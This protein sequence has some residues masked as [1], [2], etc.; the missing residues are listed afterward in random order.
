M[1][2]EFDFETYLNISQ[3]KFGIYLFNKKDMQNLYY[4]ELRLVNLNN[5]LD[6]NSLE[7]F[8]EGNIFKIEKLVG[9]F[10]K[11]ITLIVDNRKTF[12][13]NIGIK[14]KNYKKNIDKKLLEIT[15]TEVK[16]LFKENYQ[17]YKVMHII[18]NNYIIN[19]KNYKKFIDNLDCDDLCLDVSFILIPNNLVYDLD[20]VLENYQIKTKRY[21]NQKYLKNFFKDTDL[22]LSHMAYKLQNGYNENEVRLI[23]KNTKKQGIFERFF[24]L[25][26]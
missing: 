14:K 10:I 16:D 8:L 3:K 4:N 22:E 11:N 23:Q 7:N 21:L 2:E 18:V 26:S 25:F 19:G 12:N 5:S 15:L 17:D 20:K 13:L 9:T 24:Q 1:I 6:I